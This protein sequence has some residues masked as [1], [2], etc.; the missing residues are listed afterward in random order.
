LNV[1][2]FGF[3][4]VCWW[5]VIARDY[6]DNEIIFQPYDPEA[7]FRTNQKTTDL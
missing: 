5:G 7:I 3:K 4:P 2:G 6:P 1:R